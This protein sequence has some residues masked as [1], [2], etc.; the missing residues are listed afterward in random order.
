MYIFQ[1]K[2]SVLALVTACLANKNIDMQTKTQTNSGLPATYK[3]EVVRSSALG[4]VYSRTAS[5][6]N[7]PPCNPATS[8]QK[9]TPADQERA[10]TST[11]TAAHTT[12]Y[13]AVVDKWRSRMGLKS[14]VNNAELESNA[15][16]T[17]IS[18]NGQMVHKLNSGTYGQVLAPGSQEDFENIFVHGWLCEMPTLRGLRGVCSAESD[19]WAYNGQTEHAEILTSGRYSKIGC[20]LFARICCCDLA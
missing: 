9:P 5:G 4:V 18:S 17:V 3:A 16:N 15:M 19:G 6:G 1:T 14:L 12:G 8:A 7:K 2:I 11:P 20:A 13:Q 10:F